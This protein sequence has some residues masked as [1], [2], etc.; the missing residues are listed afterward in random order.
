MWMFATL[1]LAREP[2]QPQPVSP[3]QG[4]LY[5]EANTAYEESRYD[6][7][8]ELLAEAEAF[9]SR[10]LIHLARGRVLQKLGRCTEADRQYTLALEAPP[11]PS[12]SPAAVEARVVV[13]RDELHQL[14]PAT[15][16]VR[17]APPD[18]TFE[19][20]GVPRPCGAFE[21]AAGSHRLELSRGRT[22]LAQDVEL[23]GLEHRTVDMALP[24]SGRP[25]AVASIGSGVALL[26]AGVLVDLVWLG[27]AQE[28]HDAA[29]LGGD[30]RAPALRLRA[31]TVRWTSLAGYGSGTALVGVGIA[32]AWPRRDHSRSTPSS[33]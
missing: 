29:A 13:Y 9:G 27:P 22:R 11:V 1:A 18:A 7:A 12:P 5:V 19:V 3:E 30:P 14:C 28:R 17:C 15:I 33:E 6:R 24:S 4:G 25:L 8:L 26:A 32:G 2:V 16:E 23:R 10:N 31:E 20:D 21:L